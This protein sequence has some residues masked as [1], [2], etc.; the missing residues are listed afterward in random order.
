MKVSWDGSA[1]AKSAI[2]EVKL[3]RPVALV[4]PAGAATSQAGRRF[5]EALDRAVRMTGI[6]N[7]ELQDRNAP[8]TSR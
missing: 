2:T 6:F 1:L 4:A 5:A 3:S 8:E 7:R